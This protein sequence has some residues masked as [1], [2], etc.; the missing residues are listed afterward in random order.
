VK[1]ETAPPQ[2]R[3]GGPITARVDGKVVS[4]EE[5][6]RAIALAGGIAKKGSK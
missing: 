6:A 4:L 1:R 5:L 3:L 2:T